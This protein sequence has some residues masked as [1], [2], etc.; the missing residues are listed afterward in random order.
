MVGRNDPCPCGSGKKYK[1]CCGKEQVVD[2]QEI[3]S[4]ELENIMAGFAEEGLEPAN[5]FE[6]EQRISKWQNTLSQVFDKNLIE[7]VAYESYIFHDR[8]DIWRKY[9]GRQKKHQKR[10][11]IIDVLTLWEEPF[12]LLGEIRKADGE[13]FIIHDVL[14]NETY[15][16]PAN[17]EAQSD[18]WLF[19]LFMRNP[20]KNEMELQP[21]SGILFI[22]PHQ[23][24]VVEEIKSK[25]ENGLSDSLELYGVIALPW[26]RPNYLFSIFPNSSSNALRFGYMN[27]SSSISPAAASVPSAS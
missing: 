12:Y 21:T 23:T 14:T 27:L 24:A 4:S 13:N 3:I 22:P 8:V 15:Q 25:L 1:K 5:Y 26:E 10:Q 9:I 20:L 11:R 18:E 19:G 16:F 6:M 2:L 17:G 7:A